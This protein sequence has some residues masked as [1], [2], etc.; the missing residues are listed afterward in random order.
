VDLNINAKAS[1]VNSDIR[2]VAN[3]VVLSCALASIVVVAQARHVTFVGSDNRVW[4]GI[5]STAVARVSTDES[6]RFSILSACLSAVA[7]GLI[8]ANQHPL[9]ECWAHRNMIASLRRDL[10]NLATVCRE[11]LRFGFLNRWS[12][13]VMR[14]QCICFV[15]GHRRNG[16]NGEKFVLLPKGMVSWLLDAVTIQ[17]TNTLRIT[18]VIIDLMIT[19]RCGITAEAVDRVE[20]NPLLTAPGTCI[21][22]LLALN[23]VS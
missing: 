12:L 22:T 10:A 7:A 4:S 1:V 18:A 5:P 19:R 14:W 13:P 2:T 20:R 16:E 21:D 9:T 15:I 6:K 23:L 3:W 17:N 8:V 11:L